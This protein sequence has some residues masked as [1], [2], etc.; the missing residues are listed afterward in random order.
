MN[1]KAA[2]PL[3]EQN[4]NTRYQPAQGAAGTQEVQ[5]IPVAPN[6][7]MRVARETVVAG[8]VWIRTAAARNGPRDCGSETSAR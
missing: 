8:S 2:P 1:Q 4:L 6:P 5:A 3:G 7:A